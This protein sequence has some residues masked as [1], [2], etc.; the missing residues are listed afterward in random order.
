MKKFMKGLLATTMVFAMMTSLVGCGGGSEAEAPADETATLV[1][2]TNAA[3]PPYEFY[4]G[5]AI[6]GIDAEIGAAIA[7]KLGMD[8]VIE[9]MEFDAIIPAVTS[10]KASFGMAGMTV[11]EERLQSVDFSDSYAKGVQVVIVAEGSAITSVDDLFAE[12]ASNV[13]GV[14]T[15]TTGDLYSTWDLEDAG[16]ATVE[17]FNK[18]AD[19]VLALTQGKVDCVVIDNEPAKEFVAANEG[20]VILDTEYAVEDYAICFAKDSELTAQ[21]NGALQ[22]LIADGTVQAIIDTYISAE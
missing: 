13:I 1:M 21:V 22:E 2:A 7:E 19:A 20:L 14:Q 18:G 5:D 15:G 3:F 17:R 4:E 12:G 8:F 11:T 16:L 9:D 6:V 10:G